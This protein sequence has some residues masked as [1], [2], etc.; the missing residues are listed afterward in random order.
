MILQRGRARRQPTR[1]SNAATLRSL[2]CRM[3]RATHAIRHGFP[4][5]GNQEAFVDTLNSSMPWLLNEAGVVGA[6]PC[7]A[8]KPRHRNA[9]RLPV[10]TH[11]PAERGRRTWVRRRSGGPP[12]H[13]GGYRLVPEEV[14]FWQGR[15]SRL[16]DRFQ[17]RRD[18][19]AWTRRRLSP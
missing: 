9:R 7:C 5:L 18:A 1:R 10:G 19:G 8:G 14:E 16:H 2:S 17:F 6:T 13:W 15:E 11:R 4:R 3:K 12:E